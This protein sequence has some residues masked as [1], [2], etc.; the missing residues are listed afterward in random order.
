MHSNR[1]IG[2]DIRKINDFGIGTYIQHLLK[3]LGLPGMLP[4]TVFRLYSDSC[5]QPESLQL[6]PTR[7]PWVMMPSGR[8]APF[9]GELP[10]A[11]ELNA[12][13]AP[14]YL[15]PDPGN[16]PFILTVHDCIHLSPPPFPRAFDRLGNPSDQVFDAAKRLYHKGQGLLRF[17]KL[18]RQ[19]AAV[20]TVSDATSVELIRLTGVDESK[21]T[22]IHNC[23]DSAFFTPPDPEKTKD[24]CD[25]FNLPFNDYILYC[26]NDLYHKNLAGLLNAWKTLSLSSDLPTL[27]LAGP[28]RQFMIR[29]YA[30]SLGI[31]SPV[32][33][34]DRIPAGRMPHLYR[35][36]RALI[37]P[38]LA[39]G[40]GLPVAEAMATGIPVL[41]SDIPVFHEI[42]GDHALF[43]DPEKPL[44]IADALKSLLSGSRD[45]TAMIEPARRHARNFSLE[46]FVSA[47]AG[48]YNL[49]LEVS[50]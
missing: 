39:E 4:D 27:V 19:A 50:K 31:R 6:P 7:F 3:G 2:I 10:G 24:F 28:P 13:H 14:H 29:E 9:Q 5:F 30:E 15:T 17:K 11:M 21:I 16:L 36:A 46:N 42:S 23:V 35:G 37:M 34:L 8:R 25:K 43:F 18:V 38:S 41:C 32:R 40:F 47:H 48:V 22:R 1:V 12:Y 45:I 44:S 20:I 33:L 49:V 26:G